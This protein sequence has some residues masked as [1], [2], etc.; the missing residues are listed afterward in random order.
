MTKLRIAPDGSVRGL[1]TDEIDWRPLGRVSVTRASHVEFCDRRQLWYVRTGQPK[2]L[3]RRVL[4]DVLGRPLGEIIHWA[5]SREAALGW[6]RCQYQP[7][8]PGWD[9]GNGRSSAARIRTAG[10]ECPPKL[11]ITPERPEPRPERLTTPR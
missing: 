8:G 1:W 6:E 2:G 7:G 11:A 4:Q 5:R 9:P 3:M 10:S